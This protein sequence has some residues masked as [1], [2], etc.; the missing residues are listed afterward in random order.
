MSINDYLTGSVQPCRHPW[1]CGVI[2]GGKCVE[3]SSHPSVELWNVWKLTCIAIIIIF[4]FLIGGASCCCGCCGG[5][6]VW[7]CSACI[8]HEDCPWA[9]FRSGSYLF[10]NL[11]M[12]GPFEHI[13]PFF[14]QTH[15]C[16]ACVLAYITRMKAEFKAVHKG[17]KGWTFFFLSHLHL[18]SYINLQLRFTANSTENT[19]TTHSLFL[20]MRS[21]LVLTTL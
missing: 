9:P 2:T 18:W 11:C 10:I 5:L 13:S 4:F 16:N 6:S 20:N 19:F 17:R 15:Q 1:T 21:F 8:I 3:K 14:I 7:V 12:L